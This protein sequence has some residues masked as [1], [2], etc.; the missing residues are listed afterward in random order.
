[1]TRWRKSSRST[2][3]NSCVEVARDLAAVRD[4]KN[5]DGARLGFRGP[6]AVAALVAAVRRGRFDG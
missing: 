4:S 1:M 2:N 6:R 5:P 3:T